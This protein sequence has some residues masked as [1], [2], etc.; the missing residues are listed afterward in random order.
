MR[1]RELIRGLASLGVPL[2]C[3][4]AGS[5]SEA[6]P[7]PTDSPTP[8]ASATDT[9]T[10]TPAHSPTQM[11]VPE[12]D[13]PTVSVRDGAFEPTA[14]RVPP[15]TEVTWHNESEQTHTV[16]SGVFHPGQAAEWSFYS[17]DLPPGRAVSHSF[18]E[19][20]VYEYYCTIHGRDAMCGV[21]LVGDA[22]FPGSLPCG[23]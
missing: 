9:R 3:G 7:P 5:N 20:G 2:F 10:A 18:A 14:L 23:E 21:I 13:S 11:R 4:C 17:A 8:T 12:S 16:E 1:R 6:T 15:G 22:R 19:A